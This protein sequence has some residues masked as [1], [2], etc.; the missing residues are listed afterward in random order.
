MK[1][2]TFFLSMLVLLGCSTNGQQSRKVEGWEV[3]VNGKVGFPQAG[4]ISI[5]EVTRNGIGWQDTIKLKSNYTFSKKIRLTEPGYYKINFYNRQVLDVILHKNNLDIYVDGNS[6]S[7]YFEIKGSP[8]I[9]LIQKVQTRTQAIDNT[10]EAQRMISEFNKAQMSGDEKT[11]L[12]LQ[13]KYMAMAKGEME[14]L[15]AEL[16]AEPLSLGLLNIL[17]GQTFDKDQYFDLYVHV[18][19]KAKK[20][21]PNYSHAKAFVEMVERMKKLAVGSVAPEIA[22]PDP[23][24]KV[25]PLSSLRGQY[26][27]VDFWAKWCG[28]CR[29]ENPNIVR[30]Y[31]K[32]KDKGF[33]VYGVSLDRSREDWLQ[34][35]RE[36]GL[37]W[38]H[39]SDLKFWQSEAARTYNI[40][41]IPFSLLLDPN[42][43][44]IAKNLR[45][46]ALDR[47]LSEIFREK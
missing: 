47:K 39:V 31:N 22:L 41:A 16:K 30:A 34:G 35:I 21:W 38:T 17:E 4:T 24:G 40:N 14:K 9:E 2:N 36:D 46:E 11:M 15:V 32:Y 7:G 25:V 10:P 13:E 19:E 37:T 27:L 26:V 20:E 1:L 44:I 45:G 18:A 23:E 5:M 12:A 33:T 29:K 3:T 6:P 8:D 28:P 42:G 43:V